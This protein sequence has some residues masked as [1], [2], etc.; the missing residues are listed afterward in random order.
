MDAGGRGSS[1]PHVSE[2]PPE[3]DWLLRPGSAS[4]LVD[5]LS[6]RSVQ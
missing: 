5:L 1:G 6:G 2:S 3:S 4:F